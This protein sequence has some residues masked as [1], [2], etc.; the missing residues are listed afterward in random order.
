MVDCIRYTLI[1]AV[2][3]WMTQS[4]QDMWFGPRLV[5]YVDLCHLA[6]NHTNVMLTSMVCGHPATTGNLR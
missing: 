5:L 2:L 1:Q 4:K 6:V 3:T